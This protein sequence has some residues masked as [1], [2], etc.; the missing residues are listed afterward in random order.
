MAASGHEQSLVESNFTMAAAGVD[1]FNTTRT[2]LVYTVAA[3][4]F[5]AVFHLLSNAARP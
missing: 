2:T 5:Y 4:A 3:L 1:A